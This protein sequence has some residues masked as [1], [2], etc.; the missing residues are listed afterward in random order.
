MDWSMDAFLL[1][2]APMGPP[3]V[4]GL[5][6]MKAAV[7]AMIS[8]AFGLSVANAQQTGLLLSQVWCKCCA[9]AMLNQLLRLG[10]LD[11]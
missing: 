8:L 6:A 7:I 11:S 2:L 4:S 3:Q 10:N 5:L 1:S 9:S